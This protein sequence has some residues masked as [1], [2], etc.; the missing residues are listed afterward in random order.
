MDSHRS[1]LT[2]Y[3]FHD[4]QHFLRMAELV[5]RKDAS[6]EEMADISARIQQVFSKFDKDGS[7][8]LD[9]LEL[10]QALRTLSPGSSTKQI[11]MWCKWLNAAGDGDGLISHREF[12][13][14]LMEGSNMAAEVLK[15]LV[16]ETGDSISARVRELF[17]R[18]DADGGGYLDLGEL[19]KVFHAINLI[20]S[21]EEVKELCKELDTGGD[22]RVS[23]TEFV[24]WLKKDSE[25]A[26]RVA[27]AIVKT[28]GS[29][30]EGRIKQ[31]FQTYDDG[32][33][34]LDFAEL[35]QA[36]H[37]LGN[38]S[39][40]EVRNIVADLDKSNDN[41]IS[42]QE[43]S[44]WIRDGTGSKEIQKAKAMLAPCDSDGLEACFFNFCAAG[45]SGLDGKNF[46][47]LCEDCDL[48]GKKQK[49]NATTVDLI[50]RDTRVKGKGQ[51]QIDF[52]QFEVALELVAERT[53]MTLH[54]V[55]NAVIG[56]GRPRQHLASAS[57]AKQA[58]FQKEVTE[59]VKSR[60]NLEMDSMWKVFGLS[61]AAGRSLRTLYGH[62]ER[63][64]KIWPWSAERAG[65]SPQQ[66]SK[67]VK[68]QP[69]KPRLHLPKR[70]NFLDICVQVVSQD[71]QNIEVAS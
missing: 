56:Q 44:S 43:F 16:A 4:R 12:I 65:R 24:A 33:G 61:T 6:A 11:S 37:T 51:R 13:K 47:K 62:R 36:L 45:K 48:L 8:M 15:C 54:E 9:G 66:V 63:R 29:A 59:A 5:E 39:Q 17:E 70:D 27:A 22:N 38:F 30:R 42:Y 18:F 14:W 26:R 2:T 23:R 55:R 71:F 68:A 31:A 20:F 41:R 46:L 67:S 40:D 19:Y 50:F 35:R 21:T 7:G 53:G 64:Q 28:T 49:L 58:K 60:K 32:D 52:V 10:R 57:S 3:H 1:R 34:C 25:E 69:R